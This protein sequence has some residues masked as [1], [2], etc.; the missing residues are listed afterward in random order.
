MKQIQVNG[1]NKVIIFDSGSLISLSLTGL[2][3][4]LAEL[5]KVFEG[6][7]II[8]SEV[9]KEIIDTPLNIKRFELEALRAKRLLDDGVVELPDS[10]GVG[11]EEISKKTNEMLDYANSLFRGEKKDIHIFDL[12][13][14]SCLALS[15]ILRDRG[16][17]NVVVVDERT[18]R[19]LVEKP[20]NL[21]KFLGKKLH[22]NIEVQKKNVGAFK[23]FKIIRSPELVYVAYKKGFVKMKGP[24]VLDALLYALKFKGASISGE[25]IEEMKKIAG[26]SGM[27]K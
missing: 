26:R 27:K 10:V 7:F 8:T 25:E 21:R 11:A 14:A 4:I 19:M 16:V 23:G 17:M 24:K 9:K 15:S 1:T 12:G 20:E 5:K 3:G 2:L 13:E 22:M 18:T 6:K